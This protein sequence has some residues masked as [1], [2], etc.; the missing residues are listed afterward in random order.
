MS[1]EFELRLEQIEPKLD[2]LTEYVFLFQRLKQMERADP[3]IRKKAFFEQVKTL[4]RNC[5]LLEEFYWTQETD[6]FN[7]GES[8][9]FR[10]YHHDPCVNG[11]E[12]YEYRGYKPENDPLYETKKAVKDFLREYTSGDMLSLWGEGNWRVVANKDGVMAE[13]YD[14]Y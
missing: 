5:P 6:Y 9:P 12:T 3:G 8:T 7:D 1:D 2:P 10:C 11:E 14:N 4:F 13:V